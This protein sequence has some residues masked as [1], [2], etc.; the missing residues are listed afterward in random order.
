MT[1]KEIMFET[2]GF[3]GDFTIETEQYDGLKYE[4]KDGTLR[5]GCADKAGLCRAI[6]KTVQAIREGKTEFSG[7]EKLYFKKCGP[8]LDMSRNGVMKPGQ[9]KQY[10]NFMASMG[11]NMLM[12]YTEDTYELKDYPYFGYMRGRYTQEELK[13]IDDYADM[14]GIELIPCIQVLGHLGNYLKWPEANAV[15]DTPTVLK[16]D[17]DKTYE[18]IE[19]MIQTTRNTFRSDK[20][21]I[22]M[23]E[24]HDVGLGRYLKENGF[25]D[26]YTLYNR[27]LK[28]VCEICKKHGYEN[29]MVW[30]DMYLRLGSK[31]GLYY[32]ESCVIPQE[33]I[34]A[35]PK[36]V[37]IVYW[38]YYHNSQ[39]CFNTFIQRHRA[40]TGKVSFAGAVW[41]WDGFTV[42]NK[43]TY[44]TMIPALSSCIDNGVETV[45][46]T[47]WGNSG[48]E[49][50]YF[51][52]F[53]GLALFAEYLY[54]GKEASR[55]SAAELCKICTGLDMDVLDT[56]SD[57]HKMPKCYFPFQ[58]LDGFGKRYI[59]CDLL[60][61]A[62]GIGSDE[63]YKILKEA[64]DAIPEIT[65]KWADRYALIKTVFAAAAEKCKMLMELRSKYLAGDKVYLQELA[66]K[67]IPALIQSYRN[68]IQMH[69][70]L[71]EEVNK[72]YGWE[73]LCARYGGVIARLEY[74]CDVIG[75]YVAGELE[76]IGELL[77]EPI[78][79]SYLGA[80]RQISVMAD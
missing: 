9:V 16:V 33:A 11:L 40:L 38:D 51:L 7:E 20:I 60:I 22:G 64:G 26:Q 35:V 17:G 25:T 74:A 39:E 58:K 72:P 56:M 63:D 30:G 70:H 1:V 50:D 45:L 73:V 2:L 37:D 29:P 47:M 43:L 8:M 53:G 78:P 65:G 21:H 6:T 28:R 57:F 18:L 42:D 3:D 46:A 10:L 67:R 59:W 49:T 27:H 32:D 71:W 54:K 77:E 41:T 19:T 48:C 36:Q 23:D 12:L 80:G 24:T 13:D 69:Q 62:W 31:S 76:A 75:R 44:E 66:E 5:V 14:L 15:R 68:L 4:Y 34:D 61:N 79:E 52:G 55:E